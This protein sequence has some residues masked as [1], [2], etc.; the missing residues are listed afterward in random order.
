MFNFFSKI[1]SRN[2][3]ALDFLS[4]SVYIVE[5][6]PSGPVCNLLGCMSFPL[7]RLFRKAGIYDRVSPFLTL[8]G[9]L[10]VLSFAI[11]DSF[12]VFYKSTKNKSMSAQKK[13][14]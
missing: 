2:R 13:K 4:I 10:F 7:E 8:L 1:R 11:F 9:L 14:L 3:E 12:C 6:S 5:E